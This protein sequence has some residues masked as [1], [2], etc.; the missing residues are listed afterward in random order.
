MNASRTSSSDWS[1][2]SHGDAPDTSPEETL[3]LGEHLDSCS[4]PDRDSL[5]WRGPAQAASRFVTAH[6]VSVAFTVAA[7]L[8]GIA[9]LQR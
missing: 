3:A 9:V 7:M 2:A 4:D 8:G 1:I 5:A 6:P